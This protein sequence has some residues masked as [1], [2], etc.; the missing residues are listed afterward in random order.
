MGD[1]GFWKAGWSALVCRKS[2]CWIEASWDGRLWQAACPAM[3]NFSIGYCSFV[4]NQI[5]HS[6]IALRHTSH[7]VSVFGVS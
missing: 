2:E 7:S 6:L 1:S 3:I 4:N 5:R